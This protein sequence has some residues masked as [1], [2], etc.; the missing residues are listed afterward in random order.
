M[1]QPSKIAISVTQEET[2]QFL[3]VYYPPDPKSGPRQAAKDKN[4]LI[5]NKLSTGEEK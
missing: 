1:I 5:L 2:K 3:S 4:I